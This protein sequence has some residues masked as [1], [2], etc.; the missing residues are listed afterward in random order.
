MNFSLNANLSNLNLM[1]LNKYYDINLVSGNIN[2]STNLKGKFEKGKEVYKNVYGNSLISSKQIIIKN[3]NLNALKSGITK[4]DN[5]SEIN[6][7]RKA[8]F[9]GNTNI[10][11]QKINFVHDKETIKIPITKVNIDEGFITT[12]GNYNINNN[13]LNVISKYESDQNKLLSLFSLKTTGKISKPLTQIS[14]DEGAVKSIVEKVA[15]KKLKKVIEEK[16]E[17]KF[18]NIIDKLLE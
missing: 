15:Q 2:L 14:F 3:F 6:N 7:V 5:L 18:D 8:L 12:S 4:L 9:N 11:D 10:K 1:D 16:L 17:K 13:N